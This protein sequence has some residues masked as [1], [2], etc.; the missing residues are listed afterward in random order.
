MNYYYPVLL[1]NYYD[2][3]QL[4]CPQQRQTSNQFSDA[5]KELVKPASVNDSKINVTVNAEIQSRHYKKCNSRNKA[6]RNVLHYRKHLGDVECSS[7]PLEN[8]PTINGS[9]R[10]EDIKISG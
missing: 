7:P 8:K 1:N 5:C 2:K 3:S 9:S 4:F 6:E 10:I